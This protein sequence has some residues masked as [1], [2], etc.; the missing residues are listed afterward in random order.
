[1]NLDELRIILLSERET[2]RL[3]HIPHDLFASAQKSLG[4]LYGELHACSD[5]FSDEAQVLIQRIHAMR[6]TL[7]DLFHIRAEKILSLARTQEDGHYI[8]RDELKRLLPEEREMYDLIV[9]ALGQARCRL[10]V[11]T[12]PPTPVSMPSGG[13]EP[14]APATGAGDAAGTP[15]F[16]VTRVLQDVEPFMGVDG[17]IYDLC[18]EDIVTLPAR[19]ADVLCERNIVLNINPGK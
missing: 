7:S 12:A 14:C 8:D 19:N 9:Q 5:P 13:N 18:R 4:D 6:E 11:G 10:L 16:V 17:R 3:V 15:S 2:G 1:M